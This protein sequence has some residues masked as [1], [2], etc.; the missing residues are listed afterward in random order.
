VDYFQ[1]GYDSGEIAA[2]ILK[3]EATPA[4]FTIEPQSASI[5]AINHDAAEAQGVT[6]P[7]AV[8]ERATEVTGGE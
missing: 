1:D 2:A 5:L 7:D 3:G 6:F 4:D 8:V